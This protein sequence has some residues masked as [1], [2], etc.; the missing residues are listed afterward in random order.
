MDAELSVTG[1]DVLLR[2][3]DA[4]VLSVTMNRPDRLNALTP[5]LMRALTAALADAA[6]DPDIH[7]VLL[8]GAG[9]GFC[10]GGDMRDGRR[11]PAAGDRYKTDPGYNKPDQRY[12]RV[13]GYVQASLLLHRMAKPTVAVVRGAAIGAGFS[14]VAACDFRIV[15]D[16]AVFSTTF[17]RAGFS[18]D[19]GGSY[20]LTRL[21]GPAKARE[22][23]M[24]NPRITAE[25]ALR[26]GLVTELVPD[27]ELDARAEAFARRLADGPRAALR[28]MKQN[29][30]L[31]ETAT[32]EEVLDLETANMIRTT[33]S[34]D[35]REAG[36]AML[37]K[38]PAAFKGF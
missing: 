37:E 15:S 1:G 10:S 27:A 30:V 7:V 28:A 13:R 25:E 21:L 24:L 3:L 33:D 8:R 36:R 32:F 12:D 35:A 38:R 34:E 31:A 26:L 23:Y 16:T 6:A 11:D 20:L 14:M 29:L 5:P 19:Y 2:A 18:G 9:R 4:G 17:V 22:L